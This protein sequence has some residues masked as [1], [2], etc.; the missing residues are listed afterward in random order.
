MVRKNNKQ[1]LGSGRV[2]FGAYGMMEWMAQIPTPSGPVSVSFTG[3]AVT[4]YGV[5]PATFSTDNEVLIHFIEMSPQMKAGRIVR[6][7]PTV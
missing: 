1:E 7:N 6:L 3:G 4:G 2:T 5:R